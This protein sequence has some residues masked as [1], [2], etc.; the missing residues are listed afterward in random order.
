MKLLRSTLDRY[1]LRTWTR[2]FVLTALGFPIIAILIDLTDNLRGLLHRGLTW[3]EILVSYVYAIPEHVYLVMPAAV[4]FA[5]V[6]TVGVMGRHSEITAAK[7]SGLS[8]R[9]IVFP[10]IVGGAV[11]AV[12][13]VVVGEL[14]PGASARQ[15]EIQSG[16]DE[17]YTR[18]RYNFVFR[19]DGG[20]VYSVRTL[21]LEKQQLQHAVFERP[22]NTLDYPGLAVTADSAT[23]DSVAGHWRL[24]QGAS[25]TIVDRDVL[26]SLEFESMVLAALTQRPEDLL[27][28]PKETSE[29]R[30]AELGR[31]IDALDRSGNDTN[32]LKVKQAL[33][34]ALPAAC[35]LITLFAAP[36][37][38][39][40]P[41]AGT[42]FGIAVSLGTTVTY[43]MIIQVSEAFGASGAIPPVLAA[44]I[45]NFL[46]L[47]LGIG[48]MWRVRT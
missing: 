48:L 22:G 42:A 26:S 9:R 18:F 39:T 45:P 40:S 28:A 24:W 38:V 35:L 19:G 46:V 36:L 37:A 10:I 43:L 6:F 23:F 4:L 11:S 41:R 1:V 32:K 33:K 16:E 29:M 27:V 15:L 13:A 12:L 44:W 20:W 5:T 30:Y 34:L 31:Y 8:F 7:A 14:S 25:R 3:G 2:I 21:D 17:P 47:I